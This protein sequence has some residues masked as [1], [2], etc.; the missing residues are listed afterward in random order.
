MLLCRICIP[1]NTREVITPAAATLWRIVLP[2]LGDRDSD[3]IG[4]TRIGLQLA[5]YFCLHRGQFAR[6]HCKRATSLWAESA[7]SLCLDPTGASKRFLAPLAAQCVA[8]FCAIDSATEKS[9]YDT[10]I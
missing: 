4:L 2:N 1:T 8:C 9:P 10:A 6:K 3:F 5:I 7:L